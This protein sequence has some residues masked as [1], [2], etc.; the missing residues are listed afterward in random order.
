MHKKLKVY[1]VPTKGELYVD[2]NQLMDQAAKLSIFNMS[3]ELVHFM[4]IDDTHT[5]IINLDVSNLSAGMYMIKVQNE[6]I[7]YKMSKIII[8]PF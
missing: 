8:S 1:P 7:Q 4:D 6:H 3:G 2:I 5:G